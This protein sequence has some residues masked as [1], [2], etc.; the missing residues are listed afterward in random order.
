MERRNR[1]R[2]RLETMR[3][4][5]TRAGEQAHFAMIE[6]GL[7]AIA[8]ELDLVQ[9]L[10]AAWWTFM[11]CCQAGR[12][13]IRRASIRSGLSCLTIDGGVKCVGA[14]SLF[15]RRNGYFDWLFRGR[16]TAAITVPDPLLAFT[17][18]DVVY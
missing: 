14:C 12:H 5:E 8:V 17:A 3:P 6:P 11:Q 2:N 15:L 18:S 1:L 4:I 9:P 7:E 10:I 16:L 13:E